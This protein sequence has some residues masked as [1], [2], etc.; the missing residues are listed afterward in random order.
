MLK[1]LIFGIIWLVAN[2]DAVE[3]ASIFVPPSATSCKIGNEW[4][5][6]FIKF[7][8]MQIKKNG[9]IRK[10]IKAIGCVPENT[11]AGKAVAD[12]GTWQDSHFTYLCNRTRE[13]GGSVLSF[14]PINCLDATG[15]VLK[16]GEEREMADK[17]TYKC[18]Y[19]KEMDVHLS[20]DGSSP[21]CQ[22]GIQVYKERSTWMI[23]RPTEAEVTKGKTVQLGIGA[24]TVCERGE[25]GEL[26]AREYGCITADNQRVDPDGYGLVEG[27]V[28]KCVWGAEHR[29]HFELANDE[30]IACLID[31][32]R[33]VTGT[34][35]QSED[36][37]EQLMC[38]FGH[39]Y[40]TGCWVEGELIPVHEFKYVKG[41]GYQ[42]GEKIGEGYHNFGELHG[43]TLQNG[44]VAK[45]FDEW[46]TVDKVLLCRYRIDHGVVSAFV[47][48][49]YCRWNGTRVG[50][51]ETAA[52]GVDVVKCGVNGSQYS[53][54]KLSEIEMTEWRAHA[55]GLHAS[56]DFESVNG[57]GKG[58][59]IKETTTTKTTTTKAP[60]TTVALTAKATVTPASLV[61]E[62]SDLLTGKYCHDLAP[63]CNASKIPET[64][65]SEILR[66]LE[67]NRLEK[68][69][70]GKISAI[71]DDNVDNVPHN[72]MTATCDSLFGGHGCPRKKRCHSCH[73]NATNLRTL[74][75]ALCPK[76][77]GR[78][79]NGAHDA[80]EL[81]E[82]VLK[83][84]KAGCGK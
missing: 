59:F 45:F 11:V 27:H 17:T 19:D 33:I 57:E 60:T 65:K 72:N 47:Q 5:I 77:C 82:A 43:C 14:K 18:F 80:T 44:T 20:V 36:K 21:G 69:A 12:G 35:W 24:A 51:G 4:V 32:K 79:T 10:G 58:Q 66:I 7:K 29:L 64:P 68:T 1:I 84:H 16:P 67:E 73:D 49:I 61:K 55:G 40:K 8:C 48:Q 54:N 3:I 81:L 2:V 31:G 37:K 75:G 46:D 62:C 25:N 13:A 30:L 15:K 41:T 9:E 6:D 26:H 63:I 28:V 76:T 39:V 83:F 74:V 53:V 70:T 56:A 52:I 50:L 71:L 23:Y 34:E 38:K 78:C 42:C 22:Q